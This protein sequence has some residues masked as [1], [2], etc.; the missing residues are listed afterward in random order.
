MDNSLFDQYVGEYELAPQ[1]T[2]TVWRE[3][4]SYKAQATGQPVYDIFPESDRKFFLNVADV[5]LE[6]LRDE[7]QKVTGLVLSMGGHQTPGK[8]VK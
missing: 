1:Y 5:T 7:K 6:F 4:S 8:K 2:V 3:G